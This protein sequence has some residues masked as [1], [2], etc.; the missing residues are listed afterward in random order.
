MKK[1]WFVVIL[2]MCFCCIGCENFLTGLGAGAAGQET[3]QSWKANLEE[4]KAQLEERYAAAF[5][6]L[7]SAPDPNTVALAKQKLDEIQS[8]QMGNAAALLTV[9]TILK[10]PEAA[11]GEGGST[12]VIIS[13]LI[14]G[15]ILAL[16]EWQKK[17]LVKKYVSMKTGKAAFE[18]AEPD[19]AKKLHAAIG[20]ERTARGL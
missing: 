2:L 8:A 9:E 18:A 3:L 13:T 16:R 10:L 20:I 15:G 19:A 11:K 7:E 1:E 14:G 12:D 5:A 17:N 6:E 4:Q